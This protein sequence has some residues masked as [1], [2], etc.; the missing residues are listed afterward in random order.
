MENLIE[1]R[2]PFTIN[3]YLSRK[4]YFILGMIIAIINGTLMLVFCKSIFIQ[5]MELSKIR[6]NYSIIE[7]LT[8]GAIPQQ[9][10]LAYLILYI[11][12]SILSFIN[13]KKRIVDIIKSEKNSYLLAAGITALTVLNAF[14]NSAT[15]SYAIVMGIIMICSMF[16]LFSPGKISNCCI[17]PLEC[18][19]NEIE[20]Q[21]VVPFWK[22]WLAYF[23]DSVFIIGGIFSIIAAAIPDSIFVLGKFTCLIGIIATI[24]YFGIMNSQIC[25]GQTLGKSVLGIKVVDKF[26]NYLS[27][28]QSFVRTIILVICLTLP[29][30]FMAM[31]SLYSFDTT[32]NFIAALSISCGVMFDL[33]FLFNIKTRQTL[34]D[35]ATRSYVVNHNCQCNLKNSKMNSTPFVFA[36][37]PTLIIALPLCLANLKLFQELKT[38]DSTAAKKQEFIV[39]LE[40]K[41]D[42]N[43]TKLVPYNTSDNSQAYQIYIFTTDINNENLVNRVR[44]ELAPAIT[45]ITLHRTINL[46]NV[47]SYNLRHYSA[48]QK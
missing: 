45:N 37:I 17:T 12:G 26:G 44:E 41:L 11:L 47:V 16:L 15:I 2:N 46:G 20:T 7:L 34:H 22:R 24:L 14:L 13:N 31:A 38:P 36:L 35:L 4:W 43:I 9:E 18:E 28:S 19:N 40:N 48:E 6:A 1:N 39:E 27:V 21:K 23:I 33:L 5:I 42:I 8:S 32:E 3:G 30:M 25:K 29:Y 10:L